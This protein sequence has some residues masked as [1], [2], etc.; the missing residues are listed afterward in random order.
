MSN[1]YLAIMD[2]VLD[3]CVSIKNKE[4]VTQLND[5][6]DR[7]EKAEDRL[8]KIIGEIGIIKEEFEAV[9]ESTLVL[10]NYKYKDEYNRLK[11]LVDEAINRCIGYNEIERVVFMSS[12]RGRIYGAIRRMIGV[13]NSGS[14]SM[15]DY[16]EP[17]SDYNKAC[18]YARCFR[19]SKDKAEE[20]VCGLKLRVV[21]NTWKNPRTLECANLLID[22]PIDKYN[23]VR[24]A[25]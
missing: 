13:P 15:K 9:K 8:R 21:A 2:K 19:L 3:E 14:I 12:L 11:E 1:E 22:I 7:L 25:A 20:M 24:N 6:R 16:E 17:D 10:G 4:L 18:E 23:L 5:Y